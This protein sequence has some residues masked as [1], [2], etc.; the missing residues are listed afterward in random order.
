MKPDSYDV[1]V[2]GAG[3][4]GL[5]AALMLGRCR[6][7]VLV[8]DNATP[9]NA[10]SRGLHGYLT[11]DGTPP[12]E[13]L[14][15]ARRELE[16]YDTVRICDAEVAAADCADGMF[17]VTLADG[18]RFSARK[19]LLATGVVDNLPDIPGFRELYGRSVFHCPYCD[20]WEVR[21]QPL[22]IY[23]KGERGLGVALELTAW[24]RDLVLCSDGPAEIDRTGLDR[25]AGNGIGIREERVA[26]LEGHDGVLSRVVFASGPA[27]DRRALFFS[28]GQYQRS[29]LMSRLGCEFND[30]GTVRTGK[31]ETTHLRGLFVAGDASRA[32]QW[33]VVAAA[34]GAE[35]AF[36]IN[37]DLLK[38]DLR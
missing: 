34:E 32:V 10:A 13:F 14:Q 11:R 20:G 8:F 15:L 22:A 7:S 2:V 23:G 1:I 28:T 35:A 26:R 19:L 25:L 30:K 5:S 9:R 12:L 38:E 27:L 4:A 6:R 18:S 17:Q 36:A 29:N 3:P 33:V 21:D 24:S 37:T 31:Y 16:R